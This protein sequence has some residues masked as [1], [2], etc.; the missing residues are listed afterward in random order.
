MAS[1]AGVIGWFPSLGNVTRVVRPPAG[2]RGLDVGVVVEQVLR[3]VFPVD[4]GDVGD[5]VFGL[6]WGVAVFDRDAAGAEFGHLGADVADLPAAWICWSAVPTVL[7]VTS[8]RV[9]LP[10]LNPMAFS[11]FLSICWPSLPR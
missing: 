11:S 5:A 2:L 1:S 8:R 7:W 3:V 10:Y 4:R 9:P 6:A